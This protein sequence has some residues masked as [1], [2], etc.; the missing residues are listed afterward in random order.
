MTPP[1]SRR[2]RQIKP[3]VLSLLGALA[4]FSLALGA[5]AWHFRSEINALSVARKYSSQELEDQLAGNDQAIQDAV[6]AVPDVTVR[7]PTEE[8]RKALQ[9]GTLTQEELI[10]RITEIPAQ[11]QPSQD[12]KTPEPA[13]PETTP[14]A[15]T[16]VQ[17]QDQTAY[18]KELSSLVA[19]VYVLREEY[20]GALANLESAAKAEYRAIPQ[21][22]RTTKRLA[23]LASG[24][25]SKATE[26]E[27]QC[28]RQMEAVITDMETL[29]GKNNGDMSLP[30]TVYDSYAQ[31]K[32]L[33]KAW[34]MS[35]L[36][37]KG[38]I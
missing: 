26:L 3:V 15:T 18:Q 19:K 5:I 30:Q 16:P 28:D 25:L 24:Y 2:K 27:K 14:S 10:Q 6:N 36:Q 23:S 32:S 37:E 8:E 31:E 17:P 7:T 20:T 38:L 22:Q 12:G 21:E 35:R 34:Y 9:E 13:A 29:I 11:E 33:K 4:I 1:H